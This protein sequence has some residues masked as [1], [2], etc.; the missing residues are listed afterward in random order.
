MAE[1]GDMLMSFPELLEDYEVFKMNPRTVGGYGGRYG[2]RI[3]RG[4]WSCRKQSKMGIEG[5]LQV[6]NHQAVF[7]GAGRFFDEKALNRATKR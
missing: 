7:L 2:K 3:E 1:Y 6:P 5:N 4:Y